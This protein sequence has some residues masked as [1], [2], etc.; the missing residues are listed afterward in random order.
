MA[1]R[2]KKKQSAVASSDSLEVQRDIEADLSAIDELAE[3]NKRRRFPFSRKKS[4]KDAPANDF[5]RFPF[6][7]NIKPREFYSFHSDYFQVDDRWCTIMSFFHKE[8]SS[9]GWPA[10]WGVNRIP[11]GLSS[12]V[13]IMLFDQVRRMSD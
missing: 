11:T 12:D 6:L 1:L 7:H 9:Q 2:G 10:F 13:Q 8:G 5:T 4:E 3:H